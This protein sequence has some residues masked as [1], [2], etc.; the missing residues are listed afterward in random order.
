MPRSV[1]GSVLTYSRQLVPIRLCRA[2]A[3]PLS[4]RQDALAHKELLLG[5]NGAFYFSLP[6]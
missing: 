2:L 6:F 4:G 5:L 3:L 1:A